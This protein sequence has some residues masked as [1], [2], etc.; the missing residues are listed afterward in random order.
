MSSHTETFRPSDAPTGFYLKA[1][2]SVRPDVY[3]VP[4]PKG[5]AGRKG[6]VNKAGFVL[7]DAMR[8]QDDRVI[9]LNLIVHFLSIFL[10]F[11][12]RYVMYRTTFML[13]R[14]I[15]LR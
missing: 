10:T 8:L 12:L 6:N 14:R 2:D 13:L 5:Q 15:I 4:R 1:S 9:L 11:R 7:R 3:Y